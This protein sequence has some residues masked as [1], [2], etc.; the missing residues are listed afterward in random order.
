MANSVSRRAQSTTAA[1]ADPG[2]ER[3]IR[4]T[5]VELLPSDRPETAAYGRFRDLYRLTQECAERH[6]AV[7]LE[8]SGA[9]RSAAAPYFY[10]RFGGLRS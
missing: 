4:R 8:H 2:L 10:Q 9:P 7:V 1:R 5:P 6:L 3:W